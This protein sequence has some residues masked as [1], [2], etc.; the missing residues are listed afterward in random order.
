MNKVNHIAIIMDG[1]GRWGKK[2]RKNRNFGHQNGVKIIE[3]IV[4]ASIKIK[5]PILTF[6]TFSSENWK[7]PK[8]EITFLF[9][10]I[11]YYFNKEI[12]NLIKNNIKINVIGNLRNLP[13]NVRQTLIDSMKKTQKCNKILVNLAINYGS[14]TEIIEAMRQIQ[15]KK[16]PI[17]I[18]NLQNNLYTKDTKDPD[19]LI[20]T[21]GK[22]RLS[23]FLLWQMAY[24]EIYFIDKLWPDFKVAD[25]IKIINSFKKVKRNFGKV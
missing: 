9:K 12:D 20:R 22:K 15:K 8:K 23:N 3:K 19:I 4:K 24:T 21:G 5:V 11:N 18:N 10:L 25:Y 7:R 13:K 2:K 1:N 17:G 16:L 6:Y 14:K